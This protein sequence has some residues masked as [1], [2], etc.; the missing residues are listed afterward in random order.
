M[1]PKKSG[2][3]RSS[4]EKVVVFID[5]ENYHYLKIDYYKSGANIKSLYLSDYRTVKRVNYPFKLTMESHTKPTKTEIVT[6]E[7][8]LDSQR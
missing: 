7:I 8:E 2:E 1:T 5:R 3:E 4:Y 6:T